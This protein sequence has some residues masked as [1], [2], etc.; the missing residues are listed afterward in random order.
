MKN[1]RLA[2]WVAFLASPAAPAM[3]MRPLE[4]AGYLTGH[5]VAPD[6]I[7]PSL[8]IPFLWGED[9]PVFVNTGQ[10]QAAL[11]SVMGCYNA[12][13]RQIDNQIDGNG[14]A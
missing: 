1:D 7:P 9:D 6:L 2:G 4:L 12:I 10:M 5:V 13:V 8:W 3:A 14:P 11:D